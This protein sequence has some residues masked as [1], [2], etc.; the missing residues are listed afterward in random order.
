VSAALNVPRRPVTHH[1]QPGEWLSEPGLVTL[2]VTP[3]GDEARRRYI[4]AG[5]DVPDVLV[6]AMPVGGVVGRLDVRLPA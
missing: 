4:D 2:D 1:C 3:Y 6:D 5:Y